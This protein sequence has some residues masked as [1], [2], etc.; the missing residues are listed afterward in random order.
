MRQTWDR[1]AQAAAQVASSPS[2]VQSARAKM[3]GSF[4][5]ALGLRDRHDA[6]RDCQ[7]TGGKGAGRHNTAIA[8]AQVD[9]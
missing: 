3:A 7:V 8:P 2:V 5:G 1:A 4:F 9:N 6:R